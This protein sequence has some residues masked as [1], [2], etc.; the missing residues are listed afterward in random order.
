MILKLCDLTVTATAASSLTL[1]SSD[2]ACLMSKWHYLFL[3][4]S[5][6]DL[7]HHVNR[8]QTEWTFI[9]D[10]LLEAGLVEPRI[11]PS[12][13]IADLITTNEWRNSIVTNGRAESITTNGQ[14]MTRQYC[15]HPYTKPTLHSSFDRHRHP[16]TIRPMRSWEPRKILSIMMWGVM[17]MIMTR[18]NAKDW[19]GWTCYLG[20][21]LRIWVACS[22]QR[23]QWWSI[24]F[25][26]P[27]FQT[28]SGKSTT[29]KNFQTSRNAKD[30]EEGNPQ[31]Y[32][33]Y[34]KI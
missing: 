20:L 17:M 13:L 22:L 28:E 14:Q 30:H 21:H 9:Y 19:R 25:T 7:Q 1:H 24:T 29:L 27:R 16:S 33:Q 8:H 15:Y 31:S 6:N 5:L 26:L 34:T 10:H 12:T 23:L 11:E 3:S 4:Q 18:Y 32:G 2:F